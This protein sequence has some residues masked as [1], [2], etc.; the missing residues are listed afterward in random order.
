MREE[1][2]PLSLSE[3]RFDR[4]EAIEWWDQALLRRARVLVIGAGAL[5][6]EVIKNLALLGVGQIAVADM[7]HIE[8]SNLTRSVLFRAEDRGQP[9]ALCAA[10]RAREIY[11]ELKIH[12][13]VGNVLAGLGLGWFR[14]ADAVI[15]A[16]DNREA[17]VFV[18]RCC[19]Q[20][21]KAW[22]DG[23][24]EVL[25][26][27]ARGFAPP[28]GACY[29][30]TMGE[31]DWN[32]LAQRRSCAL[33]G[34]RAV[35]HAGVP[36]TPTV[37]S[38]IAAIQ[39]Q[40]LIKH[41]H[42]L[43]ALLGRGFVFEGMHHSSYTVEYPL[44]PDCELHEPAPPIHDAPGLGSDSPLAAIWHQGEALLGPL[45]ALELS[46]ELVV[47]ARCSACG[48]EDA[49]GVPAAAIR[50]EQLRCPDCAE[51]RA[52]Q[53]LHSV[54]AGSPLLEHTPRQLGLPAWDVIL[55][56]RGLEM[57]GI[58][59]SGDAADGPPSPEGQEESR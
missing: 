5:G 22:F 48:R 37:A 30:C 7:D 42:G 19:A 6:N 16:L 11:P 46:R 59:L 55:A 26:G 13:L 51:L 34:Q 4:L 35:A 15:G 31:A 52:P 39:C 38:V 56:R 9:K 40:E 47:G 32:I 29:Q 8:L 45:D 14:W 50:G 24:I 10:R 1:Q 43:P 17:R 12:P 49:L 25:N 2:A 27:V 28:G 41:L 58:E 20:T 54:A 57:V 33:L 3:G 36:T 44:K 18:N 21:G 23:A 53:L